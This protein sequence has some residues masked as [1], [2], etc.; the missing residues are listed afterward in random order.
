MPD[1]N[2]PTSPHHSPEMPGVNSS[3]LPDD[4]DDPGDRPEW[5]AAR[6]ADQD[7][8]D[9]P[10]RYLFTC[11]FCGLQ[12]GVETADAAAALYWALDDSKSCQAAHAHD[13]RLVWPPLADVTELPLEKH[14]DEWDD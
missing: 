10:T 9:D 12:A 4:P 5:A 14:R 11:E 7:D 1:S 8:S 2:D 6:D 3:A 13:L